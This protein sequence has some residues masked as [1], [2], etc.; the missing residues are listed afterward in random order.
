MGS[1]KWT[2]PA[3]TAANQAGTRSTYPGGMEGWVDLG[4][5]IAARPGIEPT[6][7]WSQVR[8]SNRYATESASLYVVQR[9][10]L[11]NCQQ[12]TVRVWRAAELGRGDGGRRWRP[13]INDCWSDFTRAAARV[14]RQQLTASTER[15]STPRVDLPPVTTVHTA[16]TA[17][18]P[19]RGSP[20][21]ADL[22]SSPPDQTRLQRSTTEFWRR[23]HP[24]CTAR[25]ASSEPPTTCPAI[26]TS[27]GSR[28]TTTSRLLATSGTN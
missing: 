15:S 11:Q 28:T 21:V 2:R 16:V 10:N 5:L 23:E 8:R 1:H 12:F 20:L 24:R 6:P 13:L 17:A 9:S 14:R 3:I 7:A 4:S 25:A 18:A 22:H 26:R 19:P 27:T